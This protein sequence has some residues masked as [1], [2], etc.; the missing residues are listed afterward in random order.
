MPAVMC[1]CHSVASSVEKRLWY[2]RMVLLIGCPCGNPVHGLTP[3][4]ADEIVAVFDEWAD[5]DRSHRKLAHRASWLGRFWAAPST[6]KLVME[7]NAI[8]EFGGCAS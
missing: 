5:R 2:I 8:C 1:R 6:V 3:A 7:R 4:E